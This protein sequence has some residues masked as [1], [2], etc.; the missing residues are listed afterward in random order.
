M[1]CRLRES[2]RI[3]SGRSAARSARDAY[4]YPEPAVLHY[5]RA[6]T[7]TGSS[8]RAPSRT[9]VAVGALAAFVAASLL[10]AWFALRLTLG[11]WLLDDALEGAAPPGT[12]A[13]VAEL[14]LR[15]AVLTDVEIPGLGRIAQLTLDYT[16][17]GLFDGRVESLTL[18]RPSLS[19]TLD[20]D[21]RPG[22][23]LRSWP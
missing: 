9:L 16:A 4:R 10:L 6:V 21:G 18:A 2:S 23:P 15:H 22:E 19:I 17:G 7:S 1:N 5:H 8:V 20:A 11:Q 13:T 12:S 3:W 14:S